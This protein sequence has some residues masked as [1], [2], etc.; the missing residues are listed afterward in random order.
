MVAVELSLHLSVSVMGDST[1]TGPTP[2]KKRGRDGGVLTVY[3]PVQPVAMTNGH[4]G[5]TGPRPRKGG[6]GKGEGGKG[7]EMGDGPKNKTAAAI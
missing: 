5:P 1:P 2:R 7:R 4:G 6:R 3:R